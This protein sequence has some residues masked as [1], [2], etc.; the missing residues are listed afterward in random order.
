M[1]FIWLT[2]S[3]GW[4]ERGRGARAPAEGWAG[5]EARGTRQVVASTRDR[6]LSSDTFSGANAA[7]YFAA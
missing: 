2:I 3:G 5:A 1:L 6:E 7:Q 4:S